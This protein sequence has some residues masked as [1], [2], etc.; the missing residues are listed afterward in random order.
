MTARV[1][2]AGTTFP[3]S[4]LGPWQV[5]EHLPSV[6]P[7]TWQ[8]ALEAHNRKER[9]AA[10]QRPPGE[11]LALADRRARARDAGDWTAA[12]QLRDQIAALGWQVVDTTQGTELKPR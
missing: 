9:A 7:S 12:D 5:P 2:P 4:Y 6:S 8:A 10:A 11:V 3:L 1:K